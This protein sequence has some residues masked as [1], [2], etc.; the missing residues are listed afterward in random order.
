MQRKCFIQKI[1]FQLLNQEY[2]KN[3]IVCK[4]FNIHSC[5]SIQFCLQFMCV[6]IN[7]GLQSPSGSIKETV[8]TFTDCDQVYFC[9]RHQSH[10]IWKSTAKSSRTHN[11]THLTAQSLP[12]TN[13]SRFFF[14][15]VGLESTSSSVIPQDEAITRDICAQNIYMCHNI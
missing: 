9:G 1:M 13:R 2:L 11:I 15:L 12:I 5:I 8:V 4:G 6:N 3:C 14:H 7:A 10:D